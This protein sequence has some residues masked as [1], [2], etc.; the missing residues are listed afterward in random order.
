MTR[1]PNNSVSIL[2]LK[3]FVSLDRCCIGFLSSGSDVL[4]FTLEP[5]YKHN[6]RMVSAIF[7]ADYY[8]KK[9]I[10]PNFGKCFKVEG[11]P[12]RSGIY[13]HCGNSVEDTHGCILVGQTV[14]LSSCYLGRS[15]VTMD[16][17]HDVCCDDLKLCVEDV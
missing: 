7:P 8:I 10:H 2:Y 1:V 6:A 16:A 13:I 4:G 11:V 3:R 15:R 14:D 17:L 12:N 5:A 9:F